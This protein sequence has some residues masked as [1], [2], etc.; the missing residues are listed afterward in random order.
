MT[1]EIP[2]NVFGDKA[3]RQG[4]KFE[5]EISMIVEDGGREEREVTTG[6]VL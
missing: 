1:C 4:G 6:G 2:G 3:K 5:V